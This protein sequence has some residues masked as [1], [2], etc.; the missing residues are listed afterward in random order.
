MFKKFILGLAAFFAA[1]SMAFA[2]DANTATQAEL[3]SIKGIGPKI[4]ADIVA[5]RKDGKY[6]DMAD[7]TT[8]IKG[9]GETN[10]KA[11]A[12]GGLTVGGGAAAAATTPAKADAPKADAGKTGAAKADAGKDA[13]KP[14][15]KD[16][17]KDAKLESNC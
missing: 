1:V 3:E 8:R 13:A 11:M 17:P 14:M 2:L 7:L 5:G 9:I 10:A 12:A 4:A 15:A 16:A 6:K